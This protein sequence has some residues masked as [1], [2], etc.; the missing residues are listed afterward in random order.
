MPY[1]AVDAS[2]P[3]NLKRKLLQGV[4]PP[5]VFIGAVAIWAFILYGL[6]EPV[7]N[8]LVN[9]QMQYQPLGSSAS[10][11]YGTAALYAA[12][13]VVFTFLMAFFIKKKRGWFIPIIVSASFIISGGLIIL[14]AYW[15]MNYFAALGI[16]LILGNIF[17]ITLLP[18]IKA[19]N[20]F[21]LP[22]QVWMG[23]GTAMVVVLMFPTLTILAL[24]GIMALWDLYAVM[25]GPLGA[26]AKDMKLPEDAL[27]PP[28]SSTLKSMLMASLPGNSSI[29]LGDI[30]FY[31][32]MVMVGAETSAF[33]AGAVSSAI[34]IGVFI[35]FY[36]LRT[37]PRTAL[38][39]LPI[40]MLLVFGV[41]GLALI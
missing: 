33:L 41:L 8:F 16:A 34:L 2:P 28:R 14:L 24:C 6:N 13:T 32:I 15:W 40:P 1:P 37:R 19:P 9:N 17:M 3:D 20:F 21:R 39:G 12:P 38:P 30:V 23:T 18:W 22:F 27:N 5:T 36:L 25:R 35:T 4:V 10:S 31:S 26:I 11:Q 7:L 29:G